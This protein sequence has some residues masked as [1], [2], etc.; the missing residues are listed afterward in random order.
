MKVLGVGPRMGGRRR[1]W[2]WGLATPG[3][4]PGG[5]WWSVGS[6]VLAVLVASGVEA[7]PR[8]SWRTLLMVRVV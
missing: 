6:L 1:F 2:V 7:S 4:G 3:A 8:Q 5:R